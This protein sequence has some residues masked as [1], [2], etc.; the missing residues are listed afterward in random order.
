MLPASDEG[1]T[2]MTNHPSAVRVAAIAG[3]AVL[4]LLLMALALA[5]LVGPLLQGGPH[6]G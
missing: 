1:R 3:S 2:D 6:L 5:L 4:L